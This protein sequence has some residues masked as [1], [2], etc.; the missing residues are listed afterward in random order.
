MFDKIVK[1]VANK[2]SGSKTTIETNSLRKRA[3]I[4]GLLYASIIVFGVFAQVIRY[5]IVVS[6]DGAAT[7]SSIAANEWSFKMSFV[8]DLVMITTYLLLPL[9]LYRLLHKVNKEHAV[10]M[11]IFAII[12]IP[13]MF[14]IMLFHFA[15]LV[16]S[17]NSEILSAL[18]PDQ[19]NVW[20][21]F[22]LELYE[23][24]VMINTVFHGLWLFPLG[25]LVYKSGYFPRVLGVFLMLACVGFVL[26]SA[27][28]FL[29]PPS[30]QVIAYPF[31]VIT[32]IGEF[33][34]CGYLLIK[35]VRKTTTENNP[36]VEAASC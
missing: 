4:A 17:T 6:G 26:E 25:L 27:V 2:I 22:F 36:V 19:V 7:V 10:L 1:K 28:F 9:A 13:V 18:G 29:L 5:S 15:A 33:G 14:A 32:M 12:S 11:V 30:L 23:T 24:G 31:Y 20:V 35:G 16:I 34:F 8:L 3:R 21:M